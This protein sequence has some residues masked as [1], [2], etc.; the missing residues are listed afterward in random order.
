MPRFPRSAATAHSLSDRV[1][2][3]LVRRSS[4]VSCRV[5]PLHVGD[6][7]L[8]PLELARAEAQSTAAHPR[9][10]NYAPVQ[11]EP[12]LLTAIR[13]KIQ[14]RSQVSVPPENIQVM[15]G[16]T[17]A[18]GVVCNALLEPGDEVI[19]PAPFWPLIRGAVRGR[20]ATAVEVPLFTRFDEPGFDAVAAIEAA[21]TPRTCA[22]YLNTPHNPTG[23]TLPQA[24]IEGIAQLAESHEL[25]VLSDEVYED[26]WFTDAPPP[27]TFALP[28]LAQRTVATHSVSKAYALAGAR[29]GYTHGPA[30]ALDVIRGVQTFYSYCA[31]R[32]M[33]FGAAA[34][35]NHGDAWLADMRSTYK[36]AA[37]MAAS[38]LEIP[39]PDGGT[40]LFFDVSRWLRPG[41]DLTG[42][43]ERCLDA[44]V[45]LTPGTACGSAF[46]TW[47][48]LCFTSVPEAELAQALERLRGVLFG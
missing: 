14:R 18:M 20:G 15:A 11:G 44:G 33:Q 19:I 17:A 31:P 39:E 7:Y 4:Q 8:E 9:L 32:P 1:F 37:H 42:L 12:E 41:E 36:R 40:F 26:V 27:S 16:A 13:D 48:R 47:A 45:M 10:H 3:Q 43:L 30:A 38:A 22:I 28:A 5:Y 46:Q 25:W 23:R 29:I 24:V 34:A 21:I 35:L 6:T 2:G